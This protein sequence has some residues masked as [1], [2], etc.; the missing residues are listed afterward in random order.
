[1]ATESTDPRRGEVWLASLGSARRGA[2]TLAEVETAL[3]TVL[4][5]EQSVTSSG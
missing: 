5:L 4:G 2:E 3:A 1:L